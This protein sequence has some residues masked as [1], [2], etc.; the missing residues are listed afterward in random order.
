MRMAGIRIGQPQPRADKRYTVEAFWTTIELRFMLA[1][2][3]QKWMSTLSPEKDS[4]QRFLWSHYILFVYASASRDAETAKDIASTSA[5]HRQ[6][7]RSTVLALRAEF[8]L[9]RFN[10]QLSGHTKLPQDEREKVVAM[11]QEKLSLARETARNTL[12]QYMLARRQSQI[13]EEVWLQAELSNPMTTLIQ[14]WGSLIRSLTRATFY[15]PVSLSEKMDIVRAFRQEFS[16]RGHF[17]CCPNGHVYVIGECGGAT[18]ASTCPECGASVG[19]QGHNLNTANTRATDY[20]NLL[21]QQGSQASPWA[22]G[23]GA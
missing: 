14:E 13:D 23:A 18:Q 9:F 3:A 8:E 1:E 21:G 22:W 15:E 12:H 2:L 6:F 5:A 10:V 19:G 17:Y 11:A 16:Y 20:E 7:V 4:T